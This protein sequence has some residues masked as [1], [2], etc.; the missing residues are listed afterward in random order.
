[1]TTIVLSPVTL[2]DIGPNPNPT[3]VEPR[4]LPRAEGDSRA[5]AFPQQGK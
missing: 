4:P 1:M 2:L 3:G 5:K